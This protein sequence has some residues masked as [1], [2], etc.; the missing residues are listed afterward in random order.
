MNIVGQP[1]PEK[2]VNL[3]KVLV[4]VAIAWDDKD[5]IYEIYIF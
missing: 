3:K 5:G 4:V 2:M 1:V